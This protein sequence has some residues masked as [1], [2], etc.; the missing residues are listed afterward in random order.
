MIVIY[1][2]INTVNNKFYI[3]S[4]SNYDKRCRTHLSQLKNKTHGN[5]HLQRSFNKYGEKNFIFF[6]LEE[7]CNKEDLIVREQFYIDKF[8]PYYNIC[9]VAGSSLGIKR[10]KETKDKI[11]KANLGLKH[12]EWRNKIKSEAS[13]GDKHWT[14]KH[15]YSNRNNTV[16]KM[17]NTHK[18]LYKNGY[19]NPRKIKVEQRDMENKLIKVFNSFTEVGVELNISRQTVANMV[20][21]KTPNSRGYKWVCV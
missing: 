16:K 2:I 11:R 9:K 14:K 21:G 20:Y 8:N 18:E 10:R 3:G 4:T 15:G 12:P 1:K 19:E 7:V 17:S 6:I 5:V 13:K